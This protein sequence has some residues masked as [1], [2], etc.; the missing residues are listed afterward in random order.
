MKLLEK[1]LLYQHV[2]ENTQ[3][4]ESDLGYIKVVHFLISLNTHIPK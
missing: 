1:I 3:V 2:T 4:S